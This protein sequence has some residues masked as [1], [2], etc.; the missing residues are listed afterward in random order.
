[1]ELEAYKDDVD[2]GKFRPKTDGELDPWQLLGE[3]WPNQP[4]SGHLHVL[5]DVDTS[6]G[7]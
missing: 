5:V 1:V 6:N 2:T 3:I 4:V 7:E